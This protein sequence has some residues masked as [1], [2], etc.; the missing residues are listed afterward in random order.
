LLQ[1]TQGN[2]TLKRFR[3]KK[4]HK[5]LVTNVSS[6]KAEEPNPSWGA[7]GMDGLG[8]FLISRQ[9]I[10]HSHPPRPLFAMDI[11]TDIRY[12]S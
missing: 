8:W 4:N 10:T 5:G 12:L 6:K 9:P 1:I 2:K 7:P 3:G 11:G